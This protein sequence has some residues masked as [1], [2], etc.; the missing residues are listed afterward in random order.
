MEIPILINHD[1]EKQIGW[2]KLGIPHAI[3][4]F[5]EG[6]EPT[7]DEF[8]GIFGGAGVEIL[9]YITPTE[10]LEGDWSSNL[11]KMKIKMARIHDFSMER[12]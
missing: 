6:K 2:I 7:R 11:G 4:E 3:I 10:K 5:N 12:P 8:F 1:R 9:E